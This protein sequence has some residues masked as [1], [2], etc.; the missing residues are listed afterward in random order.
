MSNKLFVGNIPF[1]ATE[2]EIKDLFSQA[3]AVSEVLIIHDRMTGRPRGFAFVTMASQAD[4]EAA[5]KKFEGFDFN[6]RPL[7]VNEARPRE[8]RPAG[9]GFR[10][11]GYRPQGQEG[12][13][14]YRSDRPYG[15]GFRR[16]GGG[17]RPRRFGDGPPREGGGGGGF[18]PRYGGGGGGG[19]GFRPRPDREGEGR[20]WGSASETDGEG[21]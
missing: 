8:D 21:R 4:A 18:R 3:G 20:R 11:G 12:G 17:F 14:E 5:V 6:G 2:D 19:G 13:G 7:K 15:G 1:S 10:E 16:E 9:G